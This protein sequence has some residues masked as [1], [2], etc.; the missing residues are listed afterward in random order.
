M[1]SASDIYSY[2][3]NAVFVYLIHIEWS[4]PIH[5]FNGAQANFYISTGQGTCSKKGSAKGD[6][7]YFCKS[8]YGAGFI[9]ISHVRGKYSE[10]GKMGWQLLNAKKC[11]SAADPISDTY[12]E[13]GKCRIWRT[14]TDHQGLYDIVCE[15]DTLM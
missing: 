14:E 2:H 15:N 9:A 3:P 6:A 7:D 4:G 5:T 11:N 8:F 10:S 1:Y 13:G 12:C